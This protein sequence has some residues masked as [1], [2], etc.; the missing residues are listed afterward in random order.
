[1][2]NSIPNLQQDLK[3][4]VIR[5]KET[6]EKISSFIIRTYPTGRNATP[7]AK[8]ILKYNRELISTEYLLKIV[9]QRLEAGDYK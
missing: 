5:I 1:M 2:E 9:L 7:D 8:E 6:K 3:K 4:I